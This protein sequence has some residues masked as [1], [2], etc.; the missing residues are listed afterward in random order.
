M[1]WRDSVHD[2]LSHS[3]KAT[4]GRQPGAFIGTVTVGIFRQKSRRFESWVFQK[5]LPQHLLRTEKSLPR[6]PTFALN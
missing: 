2:P 6:R 5:K 4:I 3:P 1:T